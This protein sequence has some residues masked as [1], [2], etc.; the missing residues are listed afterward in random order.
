MLQI[1]LEISCFAFQ[2]VLS[3]LIVI[4]SHIRINQMPPTF[5]NNLLCPPSLISWI[6]PC[7]CYSSVHYK[8]FNN[9]HIV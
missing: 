7:I 6:D 1:P 4:L 8:Q 2:S 3:T 9:I 5:Q